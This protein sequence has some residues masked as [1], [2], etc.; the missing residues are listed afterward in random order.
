MYFCGKIVAEI[1]LSVRDHLH[2]PVDELKAS[3]AIE[4]QSAVDLLSRTQNVHFV[5]GF[6]VIKPFI[7]FI[8]IQTVYIEQITGLVLNLRRISIIVESRRYT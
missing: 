5:Q 8:S 4:M 2:E 1:S 7:E 3:I 6:Y